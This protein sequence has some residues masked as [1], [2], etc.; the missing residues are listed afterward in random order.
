M[1]LLYSAVILHL[2]LCSIMLPEN[3]S[4]NLNA[5][6]LNMVE[7]NTNTDASRISIVPDARKWGGIQVNDGASLDYG[8]LQICT[9]GRINFTKC[10]D[11][12]ATVYNEICAGYAPVITR[13]FSQSYSVN[14]DGS[15]SQNIPITAPNGY[16]PVGVVG[17]ACGSNRV[18]LYTCNLRNNN[19]VFFQLLNLTTAAI[20]NTFTVYVLFRYDGNSVY[21]VS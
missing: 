14:A 1:A 5:K 19:Q 12:F 7:P 15:Y 4:G 9:D 21:S 17:Y 13:S 3:K 18:N 10:E 20:N 11:D 16:T 2:V 8:L 6:T